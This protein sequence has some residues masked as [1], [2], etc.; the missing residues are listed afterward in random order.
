MDWFI[1]LFTYA[2]IRYIRLPRRKRSRR[3]LS[4]VE[5]AGRDDSFAWIAAAN[6]SG[7]V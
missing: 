3:M 4:A 1:P 2:T 7:E 5:V 6:E